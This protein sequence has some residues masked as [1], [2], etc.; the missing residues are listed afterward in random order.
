MTYSVDLTVDL[1]DEVLSE[2]PDCPTELVMNALRKTAR[3]FCEDSGWYKIKLEA[4]DISWDST[5]K[6]FELSLPAGSDLKRIVT[7][8]GAD[9]APAFCGSE[10]E[11]IMRGIRPMTLTDSDTIVGYMMWRRKLLRPVPLPVSISPAGPLYVDAVLTI[12]ESTKTLPDELCNEKRTALVAGTLARML[13]RSKRDNWYDPDGSR[14]H[15]LEYQKE[16]TRAKIEAIEG[17][18]DGTRA[19][20]RRRF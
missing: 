7:V 8:T 11:W 10:N 14:R 12:Q 6:A 20:Y 1:M 5:E 9:G 19:V 18:T 3:Q 2:V 4:G 15:A 17:L 13:A 16:K